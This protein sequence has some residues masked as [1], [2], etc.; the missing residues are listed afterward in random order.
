MCFVIC[1]NCS[2][3]RMKNLYPS[4]CLFSEDHVHFCCS[5]LKF[6][7]RLCFSLQ[8]FTLW[9]ECNLGKKRKG[10]L[11]SS[12]L[13][14]SWPFGQLILGQSTHSYLYNGTVH[15]L[16]PQVPFWQEALTC[17]TLMVVMIDGSVER[18]KIEFIKL[19]IYLTWLRNIRFI[20]LLDMS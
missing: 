19:F 12:L 9:D 17:V 1:A 2:A 20:C 3:S 15:Y 18:E 10:I 8:W 7:S 13:F 5:C 4:K 14:C 6:W 16:Y 11:I